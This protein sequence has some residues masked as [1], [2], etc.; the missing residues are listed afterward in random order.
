MRILIT[1]LGTGMYDHGYK[2]TTYRFPDNT[3]FKETHFLRAVLKHDQKINRVILL[4]TRTSSWDVF[5]EHNCDAWASIKTECESETGLR[6]ES[7]RQVQDCLAQDFPG[8]E[9]QLKI[10]TPH[11]DSDTV[12]TVLSVYNTIPEEIPE[13][14]EIVFDITHG[15]RSMPL[16]IY[17]ALQ[18]D[19]EKIDTCSVSLIYGEYIRAEQI[20]YVR[21]LSSYWAF[22]QIAKEKTAFFSRFDG[23]RLAMHLRPHWPTGA[24]AVE[25]WT[26]CVA[27]NFAL[28]LPECLRQTGN[29]INHFPSDTPLPRWVLDVRDFLSSL[30]ERLSGNTDHETILAF[31]ILLGERKLVTQAVIALQI[32][33]E[34]AITKKYGNEEHRGDY[35]WWRETGR[36]YFNQEKQLLGPGRRPQL[37]RIEEARNQLAH[38]GGRSRYGGQGF[39]QAANM[40]EVL[41]DGYDAVNALFDLL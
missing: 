32:A 3:D 26:D 7:E 19:A 29:A 4:G 23:K 5:A 31:A 25:R 14:S 16:L 8:V 39:P 9:F 1:C 37:S 13:K 12:E 34:L 2:E 10:H 24:G 40:P 11:L 33:I 15:F 18:L 41:R 22:S 36:V 30:R 20:S 35:D 38:G 17:Q 21:D 28:Q 27:C 6:S